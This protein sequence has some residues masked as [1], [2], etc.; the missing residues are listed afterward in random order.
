MIL[1][2]NPAFT[3]VDRVH[4]QRND[5]AVSARPVNRANTTKIFHRNLWRTVNSGNVWHGDIINRRKDGSTL[6]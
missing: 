2:I 5:S 1:W 6:R 3:K 4:R